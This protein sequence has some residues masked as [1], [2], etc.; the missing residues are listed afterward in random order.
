MKSLTTYNPI[1]GASKTETLFRV[2]C[3]LDTIDVIAQFV[4][5][6]KNI[7]FSY[8]SSIGLYYLLECISDA[9]RYEAERNK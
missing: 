4:P 6:N 9:L 3:S 1:I 2:R 8:E 7:N 5:H